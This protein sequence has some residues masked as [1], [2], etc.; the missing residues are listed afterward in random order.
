MV[1]RYY[2]NRGGGGERSSLVGVAAAF[3]VQRRLLQLAKWV[4]LRQYHKV[5]LLNARHGHDC[6]IAVL[7]TY[8][9]GYYV[10]LLCGGRFMWNGHTEFRRSCHHSVRHH[11]RATRFGNKRR[12]EYQNVP[13]CGSETTQLRSQVVIV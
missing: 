12:P 13:S 1:T 11:S 5:A 3:I 8:N 2:T 7:A 10:L 9:K 4:L 6:S